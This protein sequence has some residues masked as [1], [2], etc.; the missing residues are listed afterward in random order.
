MIVGAVMFVAIIAINILTAPLPLFGYLIRAVVESACISSYLYI[1]TRAS[2]GYNVD[3][4]DVKAGL[5]VHTRVILGVT[6]LN[7]FILIVMLQFLFVPLPVVILYLMALAFVINALPEVIS[8]KQYYVIDS[9]KYTIEFEKRHALLW[10]IPN[11]LFILIFVFLQSFMSSGM[12]RVFPIF[13][14]RLALMI[15][16]M[17]LV[18]QFVGGILMIFRQ[19]LFR[20]LDSGA[21]QR[22]YRVIK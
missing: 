5:Y 14:I 20:S 12:F 21:Y 11:I 9:I 4:N 18:L 19:M 10:Y 17:L 1:I 16:G 3:W 8:N 6:I 22:R 7:N 2:M 15:I 13:S